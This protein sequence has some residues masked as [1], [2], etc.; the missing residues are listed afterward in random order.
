MSLRCQK[1]DVAEDF[2]LNSAYYQDLNNTVTENLDFGGQVL[3]GKIFGYGIGF[4]PDKER[5]WSLEFP[6]RREAD[7]EIECIL[8]GE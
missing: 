4:T 8:T 6:A 7:V 1:F 3:D 2:L 5:R